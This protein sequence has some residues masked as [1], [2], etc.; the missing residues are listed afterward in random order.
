ME[1]VDGPSGG[2]YLLII[3]KKVSA[4]ALNRETRT[5]AIRE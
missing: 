5:C 2:F 3:L 4:T 1:T